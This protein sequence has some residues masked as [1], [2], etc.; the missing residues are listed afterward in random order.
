ME[1]LDPATGT[2]AGPAVKA[3]DSLATDNNNRQAW[4]ACNPVA[5]GCRVVYETQ[6]PS[7][8]TLGS[9]TLVSWGPD[10]SAPVKVVKSAT[11]GSRWA[12]TYSP[13]GRLWVAWYDRGATGGP[14]RAS[15]TR[16]AMPGARAGPC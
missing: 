14:R 16:S 11:L 4:L 6:N 5:A 12:A 9:G 3:P 2:P 15:T 1:Q 8:P 7:S 10:E 13:D